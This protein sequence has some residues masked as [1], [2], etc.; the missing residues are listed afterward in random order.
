MDPSVLVVDDD[1]EFRELAERILNACGL[2]VVAAVGTVESARGAA[3]RLMPDAALV[4]V[5]LPDGDGIALAAELTALPWHPRVM[6]TSTDPE[7]AN[8]EDLHRSGA[9][10]FWPKHQLPSAPFAPLLNSD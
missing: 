7:A 6:L 3:I 1:E 9:R 2:R 5:T 10:A 8:I 4:D